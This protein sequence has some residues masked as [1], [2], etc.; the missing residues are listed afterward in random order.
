MIKFG[1]IYQIL[2]DCG[3]T[4][5]R[6]KEEV[7]QQQLYIDKRIDCEQCAAESK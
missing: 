5:T 7:Q 3:H 1:R 4:I 2:L 6:T